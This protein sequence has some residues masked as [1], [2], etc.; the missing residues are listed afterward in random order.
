MRDRNLCLIDATPA[1]R[2]FVVMSRH[3]A[4]FARCAVRGENVSSSR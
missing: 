4:P 3:W 2:F 1:D